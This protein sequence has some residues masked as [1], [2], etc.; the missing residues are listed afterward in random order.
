MQCRKIRGADLKP[1]ASQHIG[2]LNAEKC[3]IYLRGIGVEIDDTTADSWLSTQ[4]A[5]RFLKSERAAWRKV[6]E[7]SCQCG[8]MRGFAESGRGRMRLPK[9]DRPKKRQVCESCGTGFVC[10]SL[11][12][13]VRRDGSVKDYR[14]GVDA[15]VPLR[16]DE[17]AGGI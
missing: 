8:A 4:G 7:W 17:W 6:H 5:Y 15:V 9:E 10:M 14:S 12:F 1:N 16:L 2:M 11:V 3:V 13:Y